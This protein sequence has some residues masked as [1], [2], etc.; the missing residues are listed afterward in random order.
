MAYKDKYS[1]TCDI[2]CPGGQ[3]ISQLVPNYCVPCNA[4]CLLCQAEST[5]CS[6]CEFGFFL[7]EAMNLCTANCPINYYNNYTVTANNYY[8]THCE[9]G[10]YSCD[11]SGLVHCQT[12]ENVSTTVY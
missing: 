12:C 3:F 2:T 4:S 10:C 7:Y 1:T 8:C 5:N 6:K 9:P 11:G